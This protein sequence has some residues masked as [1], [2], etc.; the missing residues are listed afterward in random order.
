MPQPP[1]TLVDALRLTAERR[2]T[3]RAFT[4][5]G[6][7]NKEEQTLTFAELDR[8]ARTIG[9]VLQSLS[10]EADRVLLVYPAGL[11]FVGALFGTLYAGAIAVPVYLPRSERF[12]NRLQHTIANTGAGVVLTTTALAPRLR[13][14]VSD[15]ISVVATDALNDSTAD[16]REPAINPGTTA[17][18][19]YTSG[20]ITAPRGV[21]ISHQNVLHNEV[22]IRS[23]FRQSD[24]SIIVSWLP[25][26]HDMGLI[27]NLI[28]TVFLGARCILM[29]P[30]SFAEKPYRWL[31]AISTYRA[32]TSG[33][34]NFAYDL[35][36]QRITAAEKDELDLSSWTVAFNGAERIRAETLDRFSRT[37]ASAGFRGEAFAPCYGLAEAT[38][39]VAGGW[40]DNGATCRSISRT[41]LSQGRVLTASDDESQLLVGCRIKDGTQI[42]I[43]DP[44]T[45]RLSARD[46]IGEI[47]VRGPGVSSGYWRQPDENEKTF[48]AF[49]AGTGAG[50]FLRT[51]D[52]GFR[53]GDELFVTG[54]S[55]EL[56]IIRGLNFYPQDLE[57]CVRECHPALA[58]S[59]AAAFQASD[60]EDDAVVIVQEI[61]NRKSTE[62]TAIIDDIRQAIAE[63]FEVRA[64]RVVL[65]RKGSVPLTPSGKV[66]RL[67]CRALLSSNSLKVI[68]E[69]RED[70]TATPDGE[71]QR[72]TRDVELWLAT[73]IAEKLKLDLRVIEFEQPVSRYGLDSLA[74]LE[75]VYRVETTFA[76]RLSVSNLLDGSTISA[77]AAEIKRQ[78]ETTANTASERT[79]DSKPSDEIPLAHGQRALW[80]LSQLA[81]ENSVYNN[82]AAA[83][84]RGNLNVTA[85][86]H[87]FQ[88]LVDRHELLRSTITA[89]DGNPFLRI[90][91]Q[92]K[93][94]FTVKDD[95]P[96]PALTEEVERQANLR[97]DL[98]HGPLLRVCLFSRSPNEWILLLAV[99]H[100]ISDF[101][102]FGVLFK[103]FQVLYEAFVSERTAKLPLLSFSYRDFV[104]REKNLLKGPAGQRLE[105]WWKQQ[106]AGELSRVELVA[107]HPRPA[108]NSHRGCS[109][110]RTIDAP[111][112]ERL[113]AFALQQEVT[114][115][116]L[117][118]TVFQV[119][120][121]RYSGQEDLLI[122]APV[123]GRTS[124]DY[125]SVF[126]YFVRTLVLRAHA[127]GTQS[128]R[129]F[130]QSVRQTVLRAYE[131]QEYPFS[132]LVE[133]LHL[134][135]D[136]S[137]SP[138]FDY[139]F[140]FEKARAHDEEKLSLFA[141]GVPGVSLRIG[142]LEF[143]SLAVEQP[144]P[145]DLVLMAAEVDGKLFFSW[146]YNADLFAA[147][148]VEVL[149]SQFEVLLD[150]ILDHP[151]QQLSKLSLIS[152][153]EHERLFCDWNDTHAPFPEHECVH[154]LFRKQASATPDAV[155]FIDQQGRI[156][157]REL[158]EQS[159][160]VALHLQTLGVGQ[161]TAVA[162]CLERSI[163]MTVGVLGILKSGAAYLSLDP[164]YPA[165]RLSFMLKDSGAAVVLTG[166]AFVDRIPVS[167]CEVVFLNSVLAGSSV[168][169]QVVERA[170]PES[171]AYVIYT[172]G[173]SGQ[174]KGVV[175]THRGAVNRFAWSWREY[176]FAAGEVCCQKTSLNF[177]DSLWEIFGPLLQ[178]I[179]VVIIPTDVVMD[180]AK[181]IDLLAEQE[182]SRIVLVPS[183]LRV[184]LDSGVDLQTR[185]PKLRVWVV[186]GEALPPDLVQRFY[187]ATPQ[188]VLINL[189]GASEVSADVTY[190]ETSVET[191]SQRR[192]PIGKPLANTQIYIL[193][194]RLNP[195]PVNVPGE[196]FAAGD[197]LARG[198]LHNPEL[199][200]ERFLPNPFATHTGARMYRT[201]DLARFRPDGNIE[202]LGRVD[203]QI[204]LRGFRIEP[205]E[206]EAI[207][208]EHDAVSDVVVLKRGDSH[209]EFLVAY[210]V[211]RVDHDDLAKQ[212]TQLVKGRL[213]SI[214]APSAIVIKDELPKTPSGKIDRRKLASTHEPLP[215]NARNAQAPLSPVQQAVAEIWRNLLYRDDFGVSDD[216]FQIGGHSLL[217][218]QVV[219]RVRTTFNI[220]FSLKDFFLAPTVTETAVAIETALHSQRVKLPG[221]EIT[222]RKRLNGDLRKLL[223]EVE[224]QAV[225]KD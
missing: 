48:G 217:A 143:E 73:E 114:L 166:E 26:Y 55:K 153:S 141:L 51:G 174:P 28:Q 123:S 195:V 138:V 32:T 66:Q 206:V 54:R 182:V 225:A 178:G 133:Q 160:K 169:G 194:Q 198:Y 22:L 212:L 83:T 14:L 121:H 224:A 221:S 175:G 77:L 192:V 207:I 132:L 134:E 11:E 173:S 50:P 52:L 139:M 44:E 7:D 20:S 162:I 145:V 220:E 90:H 92:M 19:Q 27:G 104:E 79:E 82:F 218:I 163:A 60:E 17:I 185:I 110:V 2:S 91:P 154:T 223:L 183:L 45:Q 152:K 126:G 109:V 188:S 4:F 165:D 119:L 135:R 146:R 38:L 136:A 216:F 171:S 64:A 58:N 184:M 61:G 84:I 63:E 29:S 71:D 142:E 21:V 68:S 155:A 75:I 117:L 106:L 70:K 94:S 186:S 130:L 80:F 205:G 36:V 210:V 167:D 86:Q 204:K 15:S 108:T 72:D 187:S 76:V 6:N 1:E 102:S 57:L 113:K 34:P 5:L 8:R 37:F 190:F 197:G 131:H 124:P 125:A 158:D 100:I 181:L 150:S 147:E 67:Q 53:A 118:V 179:P 33:G 168:T 115:H 196:L 214:M 24:D 47:W 140:V 49:L 148:T 177:L 200:A 40:Q 85:L 122:G 35:A 89:T 23:A 78:S 42:E 87:S 3:V 103:E 159:D 208:K 25:H 16:W 176:S 107:D 111:F 12:N 9:A 10:V 43:V 157:Y 128:F 172:S 41:A 97:F 137:R 65:V 18:I 74:A 180:P 164:D 156:T 127:G 13:Q 193:D 144:V 96:E 191:G 56:M 105:D 149:S 62:T 30:L 202:Y 129:Q 170:H 222:K 219:S 209:N 69:W 59:V 93:I 203:A 215:R 116:V 199:T 99:H 161:D 120:L 46:E 98:E 213:P 31:Q 101:W 88:A 151:D 81:T 201:G 211:A 189:Y 95:L 39:F 112:T